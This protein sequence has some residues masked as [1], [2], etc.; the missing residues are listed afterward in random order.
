MALGDVNKTG[1]TPSTPP[2]QN[3]NTAST[4]ASESP[5]K[6]TIVPLNGKG[7]FSAPVADVKNFGAIL[8]GTVA[9][10]PNTMCM[11]T[12]DKGKYHCE[13]FDTSTVAEER[14]LQPAKLDIPTEAPTKLTTGADFNQ[15]AMALMKDDSLV[16]PFPKTKE[17]A[18]YSETAFYKGGKVSEDGN[19]VKGGKLAFTVITDGDKREIINAKGQKF[20]ADED[21]KLIQD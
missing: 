20:K 10:K 5:K 6:I 7:E 15:T 11:E 19:S 4:G 13:G 9:G 8:N 12:S 17:G 14:G 18:T 16:S 2:P 3:T 1:D 21:G